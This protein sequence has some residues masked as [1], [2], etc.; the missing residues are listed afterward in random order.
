MTSKDKN[1][2]TDIASNDHTNQIKSIFCW[3][4]NGGFRYDRSLVTASILNPEQITIEIYSRRI[5][6]HPPILFKGPKA[7]LIHLLESII[8]EI[9]A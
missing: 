6:K 7:D 3:G 8:G 1:G 2:K 9:Y 4:R 5:G